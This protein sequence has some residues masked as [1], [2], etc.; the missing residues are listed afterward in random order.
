MAKLFLSAVLIASITLA[1]KIAVW[2]F[3]SELLDLFGKKKKKKK[4]KGEREKED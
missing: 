4:I 2:V 3:I 1:C